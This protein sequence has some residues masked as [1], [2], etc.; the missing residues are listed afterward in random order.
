[1]TL[2]LK[3]RSGFLVLFCGFFVLGTASL[4]FAKDGE[5]EDDTGGFY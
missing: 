1:M 5:P 4:C 2:D 3:F